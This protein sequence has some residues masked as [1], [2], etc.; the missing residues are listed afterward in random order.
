MKLKYCENVHF[1]T[2]YLGAAM[3]LCTPHVKPQTTSRLFGIN[4]K[5]GLTK[6][7]EKLQETFGTCEYVLSMNSAF[8]VTSI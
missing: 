1:T 8:C 6:N 2:K 5:R 4:P 7:Y 3:L